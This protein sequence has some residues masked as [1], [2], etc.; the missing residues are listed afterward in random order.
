MFPNANASAINDPAKLQQITANIA[1][2]L[3]TPLENIVI[4]NITMTR[5]NGTAYNIP[6]DPRVTS[7]SSNGAVVC[8]GVTTNRTVRALRGRVLSGGSTDT[9]T[10]DYSIVDPPS[11][12][13]TMDSASF[14]STVESDPAVTDIAAVLESDAAFAVAPPELSLVSAV[15]VAP[16]TSDPVDVTSST[17]NNGKYPVGPI[18][19]G[20]L[21]AFVVGGVMV[22]AVFLFVTKKRAPMIQ[23]PADSKT[24]IIY[25]NQNV[26]QSTPNPLIV[27]NARHVFDPLQARLGTAGTG[28][29]RV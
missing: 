26:E 9:L 15:A 20:V 22:G 4:T 23:K 13:L 6:F 24:I 19:G 27:N 21:G 11:A 12:L 29:T 14:A 7:L 28:T 5:V 17:S 3:R 10:I 8:Y 1:C 16:T 2:A 18:I 25:T